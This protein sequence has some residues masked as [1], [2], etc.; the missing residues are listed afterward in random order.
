MASGGRAHSSGRA[1]TTDAAPCSGASG[2]MA[3]GGTPAGQDHGDRSRQNPEIQIERPAIDVLQ[4]ESDPL[5]ERELTAPTHLPQACDAGEDAEPS[6]EPRL[7]E[8]L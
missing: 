2:P 5:V 1:G 8:Q 3:S 4:V 6:H 7:G